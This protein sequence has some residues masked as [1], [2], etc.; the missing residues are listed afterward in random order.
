MAAY[1]EHARFDIETR[2]VDEG[3]P[4]FD[5]ML[6]VVEIENDGLLLDDSRARVRCARNVHPPIRDSYAFR[7]DAP[8]RSYVFSGDSTYSDAV[9]ALAKGADVL[10]HEVMYLPAPDA[11]IAS[12]PNA[13]SLREHLIASHS[14]PEQVGRVATEAGVKT[15]VLS[16]FVPGGP[17]VS[18]ETWLAAVRPHF[19]GEIV[20]GRDLMALP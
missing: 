3:R 18:D 4:N 8:D 1:R 2:T 7:I 12:K 20:V 16:H 17:V 11:L 5:T 6:K 14:T 9:I 15:L 10:V 13:K 19:A